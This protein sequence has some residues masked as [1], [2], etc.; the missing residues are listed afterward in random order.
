MSNIITR[1]E[2]MSA[3]SNARIAGEDTMA[4]Y[5]TYM[6]QFVDENIIHHVLSQ[7]TLETLVEA[8]KDDKHL[9]SI[10]LKQWDNMAYIAASS[11]HNRDMLELT[12][13]GNSLS[14]CVGV[15]KEA[16]RMAVEQEQERVEAVEKLLERMGKYS[17]NLKEAGIEPQ[18]F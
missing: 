18:N 7:F 10:P 11:T 4:A 17:S 1:K 12:G 3:S 13:D 8:F 5:R 2:Y 9:N 14:H 15:L 6:A 16:A